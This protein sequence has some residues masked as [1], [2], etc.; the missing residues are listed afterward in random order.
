MT[1]ADQL[2]TDEI[3]TN[4]CYSRSEDHI[5]ASSTIVIV[6]FTG[7]WIYVI[8]VYHDIKLNATDE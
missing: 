6:S 2:I 7:K 5:I 8:K 4:S 1:T 3:A